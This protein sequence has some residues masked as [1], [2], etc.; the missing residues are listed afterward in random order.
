MAGWMM[1]AEECVGL[2]RAFLQQRQRHGAG[3]SGLSTVDTLHATAG[4]CIS[5]SSL[6]GTLHACVHL[7]SMCQKCVCIMSVGGQAVKR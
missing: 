1:T 7:S 5:Q 3:G 6:S 2:P 4:V